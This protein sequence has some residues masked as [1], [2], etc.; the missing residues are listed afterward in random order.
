MAA[1]MAP[2]EN[3]VVGQR[4]G[5]NEAAANGRGNSDLLMAIPGLSEL[6]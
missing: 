6:Q 5:F 3:R 4:D 1:E 2:L